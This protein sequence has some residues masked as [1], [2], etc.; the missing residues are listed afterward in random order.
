MSETTE[1]PEAIGRGSERASEEMLPLVYDELRRLAAARIA[2]EQ[3]GH[4][5]QPTALVH[6]VWL[7]LA[8]EGGR[9]WQNRDHFFPPR[10]RRCGASLSKTR[11]ENHG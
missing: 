6:E 3:A 8:G 10:R 5:L 4:T 2:R 7:R 1:V 9:S 11:G